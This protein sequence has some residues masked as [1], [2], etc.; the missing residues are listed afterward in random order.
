M[1]DLQ[2]YIYSQLVPDPETGCLLWTGRTSPSGYGRI[3]IGGRELQVHRVVWELDNEPIP[4]G[5]VVD[6]VYDR[7]CRHKNCANTAHLEPVTERENILRSFAV[8]GN[9]SV[10]GAL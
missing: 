10:V 3:K 1:T 5:L 8:H 2:E 7:G 4:D 9:P 6:H